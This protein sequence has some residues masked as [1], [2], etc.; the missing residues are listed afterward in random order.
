MFNQNSY[1]QPVG[2][3]I[4]NLGGNIF[5]Q[6]NQGQNPL[7]NTGNIQANQSGQGRY[8]TIHEI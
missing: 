6:G 7:F 3:F 1:N 5:N 2:T 4:Y 8:L